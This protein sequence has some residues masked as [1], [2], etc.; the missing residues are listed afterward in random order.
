MYFHCM[1]F[2][3]EMCIEFDSAFTI[4][5]FTNGNDIVEVVGVTRDYD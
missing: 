2:N 5:N 4:F 3:D 1:L